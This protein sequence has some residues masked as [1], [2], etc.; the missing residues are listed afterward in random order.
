M[1]ILHEAQFELNP[2]FQ[3][4]ERLHKV[5]AE[6]FRYLALEKEFWKQKAGLS[7]FQDADRN[8]KLFHAQING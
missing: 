2:T 8:I 7:C 4:R 5:Q 3:N 6:L 1:V